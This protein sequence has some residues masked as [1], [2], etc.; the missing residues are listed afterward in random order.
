MSIFTMEKPNLSVETQN[1]VDEQDAKGA[2]PPY[3]QSPESVRQGLIDAQQSANVSLPDAAVQDV[4]WEVGPTGSVNVRIV[5][6]HGA[7][8]KLPAMLYIHGGGWVAGGKETHD[9]LIR[10]L[11]V[12]AGVAVVFP[13]YGLSP[14]FKYPVPLEQCYAVLDY[15][16]LNAIELGFDP[17]GFIVAGDSAGGNMATVMPMLA[18]ERGGPKILFQL[19]FYPVVDSA[20]DTKSYRDFTDGPVLTKKA[21]RYYW[22][23]YLPEVDRREERNASPLRAREEELEDQ[24]P[25]LIITAEND[26]LRDE[27]EEYARRLDD[28]G[29]KVACVRMNGVVHD[30]VML[31]A[32]AHTAA[33][34]TAI[35]LA[36]AEIKRAFQATFPESIAHR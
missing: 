17:D 13:E 15:M 16:C 8:E 35:T 1:Y 5:R 34:R 7:R 25:T 22:D 30:F 19:L 6:P 32:F 27:G 33:T 28:A 4:T 12:E 10:Q 3:T 29:V 18:R 36:V 23:S 24:P 20:F 11:C 26:V 31:N 14:D 9:R 21:M 2:P